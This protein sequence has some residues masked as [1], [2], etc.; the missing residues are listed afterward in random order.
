MFFD[1]AIRVPV[2]TAILPHLFL[3]FGH[4]KPNEHVYHD[5]TGII[6]TPIREIILRVMNNF[7]ES[8]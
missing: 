1:I 6:T 8:G 4:F 2:A 5:A 3:H 7:S